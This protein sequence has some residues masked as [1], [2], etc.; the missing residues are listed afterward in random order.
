MTT[1]IPAAGVPG[2]VHPP[3]YQ[4]R[5]VILRPG[6]PVDGAV[7]SGALT[8]AGH[9][10]VTLESDEVALLALTAEGM[11]PQGIGRRMSLC[12]R[13]VRRRL[14]RLCEHLGVSTPM[15]A[16]VWAVRHGVI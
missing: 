1:Q 15:Q 7:P 13:T 11:S 14:T 5:R 6:E 16:V 3:L 12:E 4:R 9:L 2:D 8:V 10:A